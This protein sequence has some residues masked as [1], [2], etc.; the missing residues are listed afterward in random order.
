M[1]FDYISTRDDVADP[2]IEEFGVAMTLVEPNDTVD[3]VTGRETDGT[4][5][6]HSVTGVMLQYKVKEMGGG[7]EMGDFKCLLSATG[8]SVVPNPN[9]K[10]KVG[11]DLYNIVDVKPLRPAN[12]DVMYTLQ[13]RR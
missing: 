5:T 7:I 8:L 12:V 13:V 6:N 9:M 1:A 3:V 2:L 4:D 11:T 10:L